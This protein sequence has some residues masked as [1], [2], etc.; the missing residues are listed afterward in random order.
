LHRETDP[1][2]ILQIDPRAESFVLEAAF[3]ALARQYH[4]DGK[5]PD[6]ER[7]A[8]INRAYAMVRRPEDRSRY[9]S[10][11]LK[12]VGPGPTLVPPTRFDPWARPG[13]ATGDAPA[14]GSSVLDFG[15]YAGSSLQDLVSQD[16]D[17][18]RWLARHSAGFRYRGEIRAL[19]PE[20]SEPRR[21]K[22]MR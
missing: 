20:D 6:L 15:R 19:L 11:R 18:L 8:A 2:R 17:Y 10:E 9:D 4:P 12:P 5:T 16:P 14:A 13:A 7:M 1:Y 3:R 22:S 21:A